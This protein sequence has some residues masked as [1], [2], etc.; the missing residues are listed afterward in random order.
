MKRFILW[1]FCLIVMCTL[2]ISGMAVYGHSQ[3]STDPLRTIGV[4]NCGGRKCY[5]GMILGVT[6]W[7][8]V[9]QRY[10]P[11]EYISIHRG[12]FL[13]I[14]GPNYRGAGLDRQLGVI[15]ISSPEISNMPTLGNWILAYGPP[16]TVDQ[17]TLDFGIVLV[18]PNMIVLGD[19]LAPDAPLR[20]IQIYDDSLI[21]DGGSPASLC[22]V[23][24]V[25]PAITWAG[26]R[27]G[28]YYLNRL[29]EKVSPQ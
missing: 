21:Y 2:L 28:S 3:T 5:E 8:T 16:C 25:F 13:V 1:M 7:D 26:F 11:D 14:M 23:G 19:P 27:S 6:P 22:N 15:E 10:G 29:L 4:Q 9:K 24:G 20:H 17:E 18:Y 12:Q